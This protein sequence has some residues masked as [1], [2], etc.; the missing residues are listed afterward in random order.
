MSASPVLAW[1]QFVA[2]GDKGERKV[3]TPFSTEARCQ[4]ALKEVKAK[5]KKKYPNR[6]PL[7]GSCEEYH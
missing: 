7:V 6:F 5:L 2:R 1:W 3:Y 4:A